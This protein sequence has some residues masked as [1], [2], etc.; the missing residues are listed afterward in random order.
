MSNKLTLGIAG[1]AA[2]LILALAGILVFVVAGGD[3][4]DDNSATSG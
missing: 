4:G 2:V 3:D 1:V